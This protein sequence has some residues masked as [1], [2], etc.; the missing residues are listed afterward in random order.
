M[1]YFVDTSAFYALLDETDR[2]HL[3]AHL[4]RAEVLTLPNTKLITSNFILAETLNLVKKRFGAKAAIGL[5]ELLMESQVITLVRVTE[6]LE[7]KAWEIFK[8][9]E[10]KGF[11]FT[12]CT[13]FAVME[14]EQI[15][16]AFAFDRHFLQFGLE[17]VP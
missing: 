5:G 2:H 3:K 17:M 9:Y 12:D 10:D 16:L 11:S 4:F 6:S 13:S 14:E 8:K 1:K 7:K 15:P